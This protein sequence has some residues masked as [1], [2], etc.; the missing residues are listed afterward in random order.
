MLIVEYLPTCRPPSRREGTHI[1]LCTC[2]Y[3]LCRKERAPSTISTYRQGPPD[4]TRL[5]SAGTSCHI[6][7]T[8]PL[9]KQTSLL[10]SHPPCPR[11]P[12]ILPNHQRTTEPPTGSRCLAPRH[13]RAPPPGSRPD[14]LLPLPPTICRCAI[15]PSASPPRPPRPAPINPSRASTLTPPSAGLA[16]LPHRQETHSQRHSR[17]LGTPNIGSPPRLHPVKAGTRTLS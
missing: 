6:V 16:N 7:S 5:D 9:P 13:S 12:F 4:P 2:I 15:L 10:P 8:R 14:H 17:S 3:V 11:L 1:H